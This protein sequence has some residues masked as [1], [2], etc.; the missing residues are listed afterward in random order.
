MKVMI[1]DDEKLVRQWFEFVLRDAGM[2]DI[3]ICGSCPNGQVALE[4]CEHDAP[5]VI[6]TDIIMPLVNG[7]ELITQVRA[8]YPRIEIVILSNYNDFE[9]VYK[10]L[11]LGAYDYLLKAQA[12][13]AQILNIIE[14]LR[15]KLA[16]HAQTGSES[17]GF[18][19]DIANR[20]VGY[21]HKHYPEKIRLADL[22]RLLNYHPDYLSQLFKQATGSN[23]NA[24]LNGYRIERAKELLEQGGYRVKD[25]ALAVGYSSEMYFSTAF[26][27]ATGYSP[28][29][30]M[31]N[32]PEK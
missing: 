25:V 28:S 16:A 32:R 18:D 2:D 12:D 1:V 23:F 17:P 7:I 21:I 26:K 24:Y 9:Y 6:F 29:Q 15:S 19:S 27:N 30:Y 10:G 8:R 22:S 4:V 14:K 20:M 13:D 3:R 31:R 5:D 11:K